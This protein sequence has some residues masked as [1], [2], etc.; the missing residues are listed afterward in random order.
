MI[1]DPDHRLLLV[2][3]RSPESIRQIF[4]RDIITE[5]AESR[6][7]GF[8]GDIDD[9]EAS[10]T[11]CIRVKMFYLEVTSSVCHATMIPMN[12]SDIDSGISCD[13]SAE[14]EY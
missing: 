8:H 2:L 3:P 11:F 9:V 6:L 10:N 7:V 12:K 1:R 4:D 14:L 13:V 5:V